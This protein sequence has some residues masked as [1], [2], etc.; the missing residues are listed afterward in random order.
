MSQLQ[1]QIVRDPQCPELGRAG[2]DALEELCFGPH[3]ETPLRCDLLL[4]L[5][6]AHSVT[7]LIQVTESILIRGGASLVLVT[8]GI[9]RFNDYAPRTEPESREI[10]RQLRMER[11]PSV[12]V[13]EEPNATNLKENVEFSRALLK[14][15][16]PSTIVS[17]MKS[18]SIGRTEATLKAYFPSSQIAHA[19]YDADFGHGPLGRSTWRGHPAHRGR[20]WGEF[21]RIREYSGRG[22]IDIT[23]DQ[24][25][26][27]DSI[28]SIVGYGERNK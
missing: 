27:V 4:V 26:L 8:G 1:R 17:V 22:D 3:C 14:E 23:K 21:L 18:H 16:V 25:A 20:V 13:I 2:E 10:I 11:F 24:V 12:R 19:S 6:S 5:G 15:E 7:T 9:P 28:L